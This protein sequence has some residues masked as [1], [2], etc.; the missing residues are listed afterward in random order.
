MVWAKIGA[1]G[2]VMKKLTWNGE[3]NSRMGGNGV[4]T[5]FP[6]VGFEY[7]VK[8]WFRPSIE[9][10]FI[11]DKNKYG[12]HKA[13][14]R[15]NLNANFKKELNKFGL[16]FRL[17]YQYAFNRLS[18]QEYDAD[19]DQA[20]RFKPTIEYKIKGKIYTPVISGEFYYDPIYGPQGPG[21]TKL[22]MA[23]GTKLNLKGPHS[24]AIK[25]QFDKKFNSYEDGVRHVLAIS[26]AYKL[27]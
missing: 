10:R 11:I 6:Q 2:K 3:L 14:S 16:G 18:S 23:F 22:R 7:K 21:F 25:Y 12:N 19:F 27:K 1:K 26:Y 20:F 8:K 9:Y 13:S 17:R 5:F 4:E 15:I 24:M